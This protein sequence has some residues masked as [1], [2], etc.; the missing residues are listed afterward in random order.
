MTDC[1]PYYYYYY[2]PIDLVFST[3]MGIQFIHFLD[4]PD[5]AKLNILSNW[6]HDEQI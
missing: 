6:N 2:S 1:F 3:S 5:N 4:F